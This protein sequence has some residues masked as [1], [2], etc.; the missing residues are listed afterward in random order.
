MQLIIIILIDVDIDIDM[1]RNE[2]DEFRTK[3]DHVH[4]FFAFFKMLYRNIIFHCVYKN[5]K[6]M[7]VFDL[8]SFWQSNR[9]TN[10]IDQPYWHPMT[11]FEE[12]KNI[13][14][15][16]NI[17]FA[18]SIDLFAFEESIRYGMKKK[19]IFWCFVCH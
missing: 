11:I 12:K 17:R 1:N 13:F 6:N 2:Q 16:I 8:F 9:S 4:R 3:Y 5:K 18:K 10:K 14:V 19:I 15:N 7:F